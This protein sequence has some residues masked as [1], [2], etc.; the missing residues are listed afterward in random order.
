MGLLAENVLEQAK[1]GT[2]TRAERQYGLDIAASSC[3]LVRKMHE[4]DVRNDTNDGIAR[5]AHK[6]REA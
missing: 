4:Q 1:S 2:S 6:A 5:T 3:C